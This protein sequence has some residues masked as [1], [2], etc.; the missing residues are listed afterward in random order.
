MRAFHYARALESLYKDDPSKENEVVERLLA[1]MHENGHDHLLK[2][3]LRSFQKLH[4]RDRK[5]STIEIVSATPIAE[6]EVVKLL[7]KEPFSK[8]LSTKHRHVT[9]SVDDSIVGGVVVKTGSER[10][11]ASFKR[12]LIDLYEHITK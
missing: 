1:V 11:D 4:E 2:K 12:S 3:V 10:V 9:R 8:I 7:K 6:G 5:K